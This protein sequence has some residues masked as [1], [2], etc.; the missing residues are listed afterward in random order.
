MDST[1]RIWDTVT[2]E[3]K[4]VLSQ[5]T[6]L[7]GVL[8]LSD[9]YLISA[10]PDTRIMVWDP[11]TAERRNLLQGHKGAITCLAHDSS[12]ILSGSRGSLKWW[13]ATTGEEVRELLSDIEGVWKVCL[14]ER[15][16]AAAVD[17][18]GKTYLEIWDLL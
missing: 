16:C 14:S 15:W 13:D 7:V 9:P 6:S 1:I 4:H 3:S 11:E 2:G 5:H 10:G 8:S 12:K 17:R 18:N